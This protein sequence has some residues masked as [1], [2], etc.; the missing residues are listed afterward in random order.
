MRAEHP[1]ARCRVHKEA[2]RSFD[3]TPCHPPARTSTCP[4]PADRTRTTA[5]N[6]RTTPA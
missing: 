1:P 5:T 2:R 3:G 4:R 6:L